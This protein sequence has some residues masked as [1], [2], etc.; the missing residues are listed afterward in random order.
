MSLQGD[1][2]TRNLNDQNKDICIQDDADHDYVTPGLMSEESD[3]NSKLV[4]NM[5]YCIGYTAVWGLGTWQTAW[6]LGSNAN[7]TA[8]FAAKLEWDKDEA[9]FFNTIIS[10]ASIIGL[11]VGSLLGGSLLKYGRRKPVIIAQLICIFAAAISMYLHTSTLT[12]S[13][14]LGG[15][16]AGFQN[17]VFGKN[18]TETIPVSVMSSFAM[19]HNASICIGLMVCYFMG[20][21]LPDPTNQEATK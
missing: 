3:V 21:V 10:S 8:I 7:T 16:G 19:A 9:L 14:F 18:I 15:I 12:I 17:V 11:A 5:G 2:T 6:S 1:D 4:I 20:A 13:K